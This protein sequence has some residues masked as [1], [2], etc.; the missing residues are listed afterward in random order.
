MRFGIAKAINEF[1][2]RFFP[3]VITI[4]LLDFVKTVVTAVP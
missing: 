2:I 4:R 3:N 1:G